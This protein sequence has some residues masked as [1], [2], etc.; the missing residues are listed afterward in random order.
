MFSLYF[1]YQQ[2]VKSNL[3]TWKEGNSE[4]ESGSGFIRNV[5]HL[6]ISAP[7]AS[8]FLFVF[9]ILF[10]WPSGMAVIWSFISTSQETQQIEECTG[11][12][13]QLPLV[14]TKGTL[15]TSKRAYPGLNISYYH[16]SLPSHNCPVLSQASFWRPSYQSLR[17][18][19]LWPL[20]L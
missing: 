11:W 12:S 4:T 16:S 9:K 15:S 18:N 13:D 14:V 2:R 5:C 3:F 1:L 10:P 20:F 8:V 19:V 17:R 6:L 7:V